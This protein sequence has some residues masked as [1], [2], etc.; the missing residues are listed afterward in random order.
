MENVGIIAEYNPF[1]KGHLYQIENLKKSGAKT[2]TVCMSGNYVQR[3][4]PAVVEKHK[5]AYAAVISGADLVIELPVR[6]SLSSARDFA[7]GGVFLLNKT[8]FIDTLCFGSETGDSE[9]MKTALFYLKK[10]EENGVVKKYIEKGF[11]FAAARDAALTEAG[12]PFVPREPN[13]ILAFEYI[14]S[15]EKLNSDIL[16][17]PITRT[18]GYHDETSLFSA[19]GIRKKIRDGNLSREDIPEISFNII[20]ECKSTGDII[21]FE[22]FETAVLSFLKRE[23]LYEILDAEALYALPS[24]L[25]FRIRKYAK[26]ASS[27]SELYYSVKTKRYAMSAVRRGI[28]SMF[29]NLKKD[30]LL[31]SYFHVLAFNE[32]GRALL[33]KM[34]NLDFPIYHSLPSEN[35]FGF[36]EDMKTDVFADNIYSLCKEKS[37]KGG[38]SFYNTS[39]KVD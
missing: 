17:Y 7:F 4:E 6:Y 31:P 8:G 35:D 37:E 11:S 14:S 36:S 34:K 38:K 9:L 22:K 23:S 13:D 20:S 21:S 25:L 32:K 28:I 12:S 10:A 29:F 16:P 3:C 1:H 30:I 39:I 18:G 26:N 15:L 2:I 19:S 24:E 33:K 27:L 5:R